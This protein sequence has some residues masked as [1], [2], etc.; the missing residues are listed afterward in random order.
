MQALTANQHL[1]SRRWVANTQFDM[2]RMCLRRN[3]RGDEESAREFAAQARAT[4]TELGLARTL[5]ML[6]TLPA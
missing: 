3:N 1:G 4:A 2:A 6:E 5:R